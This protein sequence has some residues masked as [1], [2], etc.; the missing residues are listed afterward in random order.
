MRRSKSRRCIGC[1]LTAVVVVAAASDAAA[2]TTAAAA[3]AASPVAPQENIVTPENLVLYAVELERLT[4]TEG[5]AAYGDLSDPFIPIGELSRLLEMDVDVHPAERRILGRVGES[6]RNLVVDL[7]TGTARD[8]PRVVKL[9]TA[10]VAVTPTEIYLRAGLA[11]Q[12]FPFKIEV[13]SEALSITIVPAEQLPIQM[14]L[15][16]LAR[17]R[18]AGGDPTAGAT[19]ETLRV[20]TPY[21]FASLPA[22]DVTVGTGYQTA[23]SPSVP[24]RYDI[25]AA[26]DLF[27]GSFEGYLGSD[28]AGQPSSAR[29][30]L[31][32]RS[33]EGGLLGP[34]KARVVSIGDVFTP[35]MILGATGAGG[36]GVALST[37]PLDQTN[38][39]SRVDLRGELPLGYDVELYVN[40]VLRSGQNTPAKGRYEFLNVP[41]SPGVNIVRVVTYGPRGERNEDVRIINVGGGMLRKGEATF[42]LGVVEQERSVISISA[43]GN[44]PDP[45]TTAPSGGLR[46]VANFNYGLSP[47]LTLSSSAAYISRFEDVDGRGIASVGARTSLFGF[48]TQ[49]D[50]AADDRGGAGAFLG[51]AGQWK[52]ASIV[53]QHGEFRGGFLDENGSGFILTNPTRRRSELSV[54]ASLELAGRIIP[55]A[56]RASR[57]VY[58]DG[59]EVIAAS[60]RASSTVANLMLTSGLEYERSRSA[61]TTN[62]RLSG[63]LAASAFR[64]Y[65]WQLRATIDYDILPEFTARTLA[66]TADRDISETWALRFGIGQPLHALEDFNFTAAS[67]HR[68]A[69]GDL[70]LTGEYDNASQ[71]Y[72]IGAQMSFGLAYNPVVGRYQITRSGPGSSGSVLFHAFMDDNGNGRFDPGEEPVRNV[73]VQGGERRVS[74]DERG[75]AYISG[76]ASSSTARLVVGL[77]EVDNP[78]VQAPP[79]VIELR[80]RAGDLVEIAYPMRP[81]GDVLVRLLLKRPDGATVGLAAARIRL[82]GEKGQVIEAGTEFDGTAAFTAVPVGRYKVELDPAQAKRLRMRMTAEHTAEVKSDGFGDDVQ[83]E[84]VFEPRPDEQEQEAPKLEEPADQ[85]K[86]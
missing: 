58:A 24:L 73:T 51:M 10:D 63:F 43:A 75:R 37:V 34:L 16:R 71:S 83:A 69:I 30:L 8:G 27:Y 66:I 70:A 9:E 57:I 18:T 36:R 59:D 56:T 26:A 39:F 79:S 62:Q 6:R 86:G 7:A 47:Y 67:I 21:Q 46:A 68:L 53:L 23:E 15:E 14:R 40:D 22:F 3:P 65:L 82:V 19:A 44:D 55:V 78:S 17:A 12:L 20:P 77:D 28:E 11:Q 61:T 29:V 38:I 74:T 4:L 84:V 45:V 85:A 2:Q 42:E 80:P 64:D 54:D 50:V 32:R 13:N 52:G 1:A 35:S 60:A 48:S 25:R 41:L 5:F 76:V 31:Q 49:F 81:T 33:V 72:R